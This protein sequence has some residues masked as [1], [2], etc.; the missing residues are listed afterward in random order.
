LTFN[1]LNENVPVVIPV[2]VII[3]YISLEVM[4][5]FRT[6]PPKLPLFANP[7]VVI[8]LETIMF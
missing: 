5:V 7:T 6:T 1:R 2:T 3:T 4:A 8:P